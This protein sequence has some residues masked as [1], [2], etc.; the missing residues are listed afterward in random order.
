M[1]LIS[2]QFKP[3]RTDEEAENTATQLSIDLQ[4]LLDKRSIPLNV[5]VKFIGRIYK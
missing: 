1:A 2:K 5:V 3:V 4:K